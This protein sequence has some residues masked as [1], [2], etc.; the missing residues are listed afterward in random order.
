MNIDENEFYT[1]IE[2]LLQKQ[3]AYK[4]TLQSNYETMQNKLKSLKQEEELRQLIKETKYEYKQSNSK[5]L[6]TNQGY[7]DQFKLSSDSLIKSTISQ[8]I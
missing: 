5:Q 8:S 3:N 4:Q 7:Y 1:K 6:I 2:S